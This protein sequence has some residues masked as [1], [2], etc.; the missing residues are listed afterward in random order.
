MIKSV[1]YGLKLGHNLVKKKKRRPKSSS[2]IG[3]TGGIV[4]PKEKLRVLSPSNFAFLHCL[5]VKI[6]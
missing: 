5:N 3:V 6:E 4:T 2:M 1:Y